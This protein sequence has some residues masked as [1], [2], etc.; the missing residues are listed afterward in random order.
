MAAQREHP[1]VATIL[2]RTL[3]DRRYFYGIRTAAAATLSRHAKDEIGW[4]GLFL[5]EKAFQ[6]RYC[7]SD[8]RM[9][10]PNDFS[11]RASYA[12]QNAIPRAVAKIRDNTGKTPFRVRHFL[13]EKLRYNDNSSNDYSDCYYVAT[14]MDSLS[15]AMATKPSQ[16]SEDMDVDE[17]DGD[18]AAFHEACLE[19]IDRKR[20]IDQWIPSYHNI[21]SITALECNTRLTK[22]GV[23]PQNAADFLHYTRDGYY[24]D[25]RIAAFS[26]LVELGLVKVES[27]LNWFLFV[28]STDPSPHVRDHLFRL[29]GTTLGS[30][31]IGEDASRVEPPATQTNGLIIE[32]EASTEERKTDIARKQTV[33]GALAALKAEL[34]YNQNLKTNLWKAVESP[35]LSLVE[36]GQLLEICS[37]LYTPETSIMVAL[38]FPKYV[39]LEVEKT[40]SFATLPRL[41]LLC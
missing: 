11:N 2:V 39:R 25:L 14:L 8:S 17:E 3:M 36:I 35:A 4:L 21:L 38:K 15:E 26:D 18:D 7:F 16:P 31:A 22:M 37:L 27:I 23:I 41:S 28:M 12:I 20:R 19:E 13:Y 29:F 10:K 33:A 6:E 5:L 32:Q 24:D 9:T 34:S 30:I 40:V 1:L